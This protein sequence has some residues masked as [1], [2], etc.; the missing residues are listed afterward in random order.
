M[1]EANIVEPDATKWTPGT[2]TIALAWGIIFVGF[3]LVVASL[4][5]NTTVVSS[6]LDFISSSS[7]YNIGALQHQMML[8]HGGLAT[9]I[10]GTLLYVLG[11][12]M[13]YLELLRKGL[14]K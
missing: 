2:D 14:E 10:T 4:M 1:I 13:N 7:V 12:M 5:K 11:K 8:F 3:C 6:S 9:I